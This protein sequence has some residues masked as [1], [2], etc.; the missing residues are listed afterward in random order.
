MYMC[1]YVVLCLCFVTNKPE[2]SL[3]ANDILRL[4]F[5]RALREAKCLLPEESQRSEGV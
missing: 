1:I 4:A 2:I 5:R 3:F